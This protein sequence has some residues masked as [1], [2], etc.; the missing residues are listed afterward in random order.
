MPHR[1]GRGPDRNSPFR[2]TPGLFSGIALVREAKGL[3]DGRLHPD[4]C[5]T[6][7]PPAGR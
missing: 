1:R 4:G 7:K 5:N 2:H 6:A 3:L